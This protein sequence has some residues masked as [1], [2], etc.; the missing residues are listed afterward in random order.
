MTESY[1]SPDVGKLR[2][3]LDDMRALATRE[4]VY[5]GNRAV[6]SIIAC[7]EPVLDALAEDA[8]NARAEVE[9]LTGQI[10]AAKRI[11]LG[12]HLGRLWVDVINDMLRALD[13]N[14]T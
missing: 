6:L 11:G 9:R 7:V 14:D 13:G 5:N 4:G 2:R 3:W 1:E 8:E 12:S 10:E